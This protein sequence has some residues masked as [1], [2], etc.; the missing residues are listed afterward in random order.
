MNPRIN[1][2]FVCS[3]N[4][5]QSKTAEPIFKDHIKYN[6]KSAGTSESAEQKISS[7]L[8]DWADEIYVME[9]KYKRIIERKFG[10]ISKR[11]TILDILDDYQYMDLELVKELKNILN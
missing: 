2:L 4:R 6:V 9:K 11:I 5:W 8:I 1:V 10:R 7:N 3:R